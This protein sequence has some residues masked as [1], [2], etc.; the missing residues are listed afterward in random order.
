MLLL[1]CVS[2]HKA[3]MV[4][5]ARLQE[6]ESLFTFLDDVYAT[7]APERVLAV[8]RILQQEIQTHCCIS[9]HHDKTQMWNRG[10]QHP[11]GCEFLTMAA[12]TI[13]PNAVVWRGDTQ[14]APH[15]QGIIVLGSPVGQEAFIT[16]QLSAKREE[17][18]VLL[19][20]IPCVSDVQTAWLL[21]LFCGA[22]RGQL[23]DSDSEPQILWRFRAGARP[24]CDA[25][26]G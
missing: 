17:H 10:G 13:D 11:V 26:F 15:Q 6:G 2:L 7:C 21:L 20:R 8:H 12:Q 5:N 24:S 1:F 3:L 4:A 23:L 18:Q 16:A 14:L 9:V 25:M 22:T 19:D